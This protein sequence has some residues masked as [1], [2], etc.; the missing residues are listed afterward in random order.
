MPRP[1]NS[2]VNAISIGPP[3]KPYDTEARDAADER[4]NWRRMLDRHVAA[5]EESENPGAD[6]PAIERMLTL[7][8][9]YRDV[10]DSIAARHLA[11]A[12]G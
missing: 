5:F 8:M 10:E 6:T 12:E 7:L 1:W 2:P 9:G 11:E 4:L 3:P